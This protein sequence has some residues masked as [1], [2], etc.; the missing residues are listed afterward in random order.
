MKMIYQLIE[1]CEKERC[2]P[3]SWLPQMEKKWKRGILL[4]FA[5]FMGFLQQRVSGAGQISTWPW[6]DRSVTA[7]GQISGS[8]AT[9]VSERAHVCLLPERAVS[10]GP[11]PGTQG[12]KPL[13]APN[14]SAS[15]FPPISLEK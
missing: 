6:E 5:L 8:S 14:F 15:F 9:G 11:S 1:G 7:G 10:P 12:G 3:A 2:G 13:F 4:G